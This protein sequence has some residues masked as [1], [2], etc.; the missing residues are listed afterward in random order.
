MNEWDALFDEFGEDAVFSAMLAS[1]QSV[2]PEPIEFIKAGWL[3]T[4]DEEVKAYV[5]EHGHPPSRNDL[6]F[7]GEKDGW[8]KRPGAY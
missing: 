5:K 7:L 6:V 1:I 8:R 4:S 2:P 3:K